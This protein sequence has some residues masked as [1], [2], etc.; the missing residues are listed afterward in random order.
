M[1]PH[2]I[3]AKL[4][5]TDETAVSL[6][7]IVP[8]FHRWIQTQAVPGL[9]I[10]VADYKHVQDGPG[11][12]I[13]GHEGDYALDQENGRSGLL[14]TRKR[15]WPT[16]AFKERL[17][18]VVW[19]AVQAAQ[20]LAADETLDLNFRTDEIQLSF[21]DRLNVPNTP[22]TLAALQD[23]IIAVL[24]EIYGT[25]EITLATV[26]DDVKRPFTI[27]ATIANAPTLTHLNIGQLEQIA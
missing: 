23:D 21:P 25:S 18:L 3:N 13:I 14:Y 19:L 5:V 26:S 15:E 24:A 8:V 12:L 6:T 16:P 27:Q 1:I 11:I 22:E 20:I 4:F 10:D 9:L 2:R 17:R 7:A